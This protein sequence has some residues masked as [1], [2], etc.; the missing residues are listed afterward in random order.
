MHAGDDLIGPRDIKKGLRM[1]INTH[2]REVRES[3]EDVEQP[4]DAGAAAA[5]EQLRDSRADDTNALSEE[6]IKQVMHTCSKLRIVPHT[7]S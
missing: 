3:A 7:S 4:A 2:F 5:E 6:Q 1:L